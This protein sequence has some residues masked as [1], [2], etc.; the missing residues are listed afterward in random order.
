MEEETGM[1]NNHAEND[2]TA[3]DIK[4]LKGLSGVRKRPAMYIGS[5]G[6][7]GLHHLV[8]EVVDNSID[9][10]MM[11]FCDKI[12]IVI[13]PDNFV[14]IVDNGRG[15]P[16]D[17]HPEEGRSAAEVVLTTLHSGGKFDKKSYR[18][19][20]GL[21]GVGLSV[22]NALSVQLTL[23]V[24]RD[25]KVYQQKYSRGEPITPL[26]E[27]GKTTK[28]GTKI[29]FKPDPEIF[30][31]IEFNY[32]YLAKRLR[33]LAFLNPGLRISIRDERSGKKAEFLY[34]GGIV[35]FVEYLNKDKEVLN[36]TPIYFKGEKDG[37]Y[38]EIAMQYNTEYQ[39]T[40][41]SFAN[42]INTTEGGTH[43]VGFKSALTRTFN[44]YA[45]AHKI[46]K[47]NEKDTITGSD[48][49]EG[50]VAVISVKLP[51]P[52][53]EGQTKTK[54]GNSEVKGL[55]ESIVNEKLREYLEE[56]P[57][58]AK[59]LLDK[60]LRA[61][62]AREAARH[63]RELARRK[64]FLES[65]SLP[66]KLADCQEKDPAKSELFIVEGESAGGSA[67]QGRDR[68]F[69][70]ILP[71]RGKILNVEK[72]RYDKMLSNEE[73]QVLVAALG[74]G[75]G[76]DEFDISRL[77]YH[78]IIIMTDADVDGSHI[79]TLLLTF[80]YRQ[81]RPI[82]EHGYLYI[83]QPPLYKVKAGKLER[84]IKDDAELESFLLEAGSKD[85][86]V[87]VDG[88]ALEEKEAMAFLKII[89]ELRQNI[90]RLVKWNLNRALLTAL[91]LSPKL[92]HDVLKSESKL[93]ELVED[94]KAKVSDMK[95]EYEIV[96]DDEH[97]VKEAKL[98]YERAGETGIFPINFELLTSPEFEML[99]SRVRMIRSYGLFNYTAGDEK[100]DNP[101]AL[102]EYILRR[103]QKGITLQR[104]KGLGEMNPE[105][106]WET[107]MNPATR[108]LVQ[109]RLEDAVEADRMFT[110]LMGENVE[111]RRAFI[112]A[113]ALEVRNLDI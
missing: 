93:R 14:T 18:I 35:S 106:L 108:R 50:L 84:Y 79:Q 10:A 59:V 26:E 55:V 73:I 80:F 74:C 17:Y 112:E 37:T 88:R 94:M 97:G 38:V 89:I 47:E 31:S 68:R 110:I 100:F 95:I 91:V 57:D 53:F 20:G 2:Y 36:P 81:M 78:K 69:Q 32:D 34:E 62:R 5:T 22:V 51:E 67:K 104:Y 33:E 16:V 43:L 21:H 41:F 56:H 99:Q 4:V 87:F 58:E 19:S 3:K 70:A 66:G 71:L 27:I 28:R 109:V 113:N 63:A 76:E 49:R 77:R 25:G 103:G 85:L 65:S 107:T 105:Q 72:A 46:I 11:G 90:E 30:E 96:D 1:N 7:E 75:I 83:A 82:V 6:A 45:V 9:E 60:V 15:I 111:P 8:F 42:N 64:G 52:Q 48:V 13:Y 61:A 12:D 101:I 40:I 102:L 24:W 44:S 23:E 39:E 54:L 92:S 86:T 29:T 98:K